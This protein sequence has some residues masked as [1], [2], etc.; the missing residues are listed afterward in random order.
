VQTRRYV[1]AVRLSGEAFKAE[2][3]LA[4]DLAAGHRYR[5][6]TAA[7][8]AGVGQGRDAG[9]LTVEARA[10]L[11]R[12]ALAWLKA[13]LAAWRSHKDGDLRARALRSWRADKALAGVRDPEGLAKLP[14]G[15][16]AA[17]TELWVEVE[18]LLKLAP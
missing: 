1:G 11:R 6:A 17:W 7:A 5:A 8:L 16:H 3:K 10:E 2:E 4:N 14:P 18:K 13:D 9:K 15:E 12:Q